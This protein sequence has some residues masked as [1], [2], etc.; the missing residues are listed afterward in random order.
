MQDNGVPF[1]RERLIKAQKMMQSDIDASVEK[2]YKHDVIKSFEEFQGKPFNPGSTQQLR[3]LLFDH[4]GLRP[5]GK[6]TGTQAD[7]TD[8]EVLAELA[9]E[10]EIPGLILEIRQSSKIKNTYLDKIIP[11]LDRDGRLRTNF[12]LHGTTSGRLSS[13]G[14]LN[15]Q[16]LPRDNPAVKGSIK[17]RP[18]YKIVSMDLTTA[19]VYVAAVLSGDKALM[20]V[21]RSGGDFHST[22]AKQVFKLSCSVEEVK[23]LYPLE[24]QAAKA[25][26]FGIN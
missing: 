4:V 18:G 11:S 14:K 26:T 7:S 22:I 10:H 6:K 9:Q 2:L 25:I 8:K 15:M 23:K 13:S 19:E 1:D 12:N 20:D 16:Q 3:K 21:F 17:A 5:T 24:R